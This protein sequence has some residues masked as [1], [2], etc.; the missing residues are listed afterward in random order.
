MA[1]EYAA[2]TLCRSLLEADTE[3]A[4]IAILLEAGY[5]N[6]SEVWRFYGD[7]ENNWAQSGN[8]Q[9]LAEA[10]LAEKVVNAVDA[11][12]MGECLA[13][14]IDPTSERAPRSIR[15]AVAWFFD[16]SSGEKMA[17]GG[18]VEDW[19]SEKIRSVAG[20]ITLCATGTRPDTL[21]LTISDNGE[22]QTPRRLPDTILS[23]NKSN[24]LYIPFV[25]GQFNQGGTGALRFCGRNNIQ[26][27]IS[28]RNPAILNTSCNENDLEWGF[29]I[30]RRE[31]PVDGKRRN[32]VYTYL[33]PCDILELKDHHHGKILSFRADQFGIFP[34]KEGPYSRT[35][36]FGTCIKLYEY[37]YI[38]EKSNILRGKSFLSRL[39]LLL[40]EIALPARMY[41]YRRDK[42]GNLHGPGSRE[43]TLFGLRRRLL[44]SENVEQGFPLSIPF[45][46][47]GQKLVAHVF[48]FKRAGSLRDREDDENDA[49]GQAKKRLGGLRGYRKREGIVF[50]RNGQTSGESP[51]G[52]LSTRQFEDEAFG[53]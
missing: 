2:L 40:P 37:Q 38:G 41:D 39:D 3:Q 10:A 50:V 11:R 17:T 46:P 9:S 28:R 25:Q 42:R 45:S 30:V 26:L 23:L 7:V 47:D 48:A 44:G 51:Q 14:R 13:R 36:E 22:G 1:Q 53:R 20:G 15:Q 24:K 43:T 18:Y 27:V 52:F 4:V 16:D 29:T 49:E 5:W 6:R 35:A 21:S 32:S 12:L 31:R 19:P 8:Q 33:A 34:D